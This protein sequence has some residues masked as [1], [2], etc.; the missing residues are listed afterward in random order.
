MDRRAIPDAEVV[1]AIIWRTLP[2]LIVDQFPASSQRA[3]I[4][5]DLVGVASAGALNLRNQSGD[6]VVV[7]GDLAQCH[8]D[9]Q[10]A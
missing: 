4:E 6:I 10:S 8:R 9:R 3:D 2:R 5:N 1:P 7:S